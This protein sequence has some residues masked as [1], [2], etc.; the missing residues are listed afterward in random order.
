MIKFNALDTG[1]LTIVDLAGLSN[2]TII[3]GN[4]ASASLSPLGTIA[5][6][7]LI[8]SD[9][10][11]RSRLITSKSSQLT[12]QIN[13]ADK[14]RDECFYEIR[15][16]SS[17]AAKSSITVNAAAGETLETFLKPYNNAPKEPMMSETSTLK[18]MQTKYIADQVLQNAAVT[19]QLSDVFTNMFSSNDQVS[20][21][22]NARALEDAQKNGPSPSNLRR[23][24][25][26]CY[27]SFCDIVVQSLR[28][29]PTTPIENLFGV[30]NEIRIKYAKFLPT[31]LT[32]ANTSI[33][34]IPT[35]TYT[36]KDVT[37]IPIVSV[38]TGDDKFNELRFSVDY[39]VTYRNNIDVGEAKIIVHGKGKYQGSY[40]STFHIAVNIE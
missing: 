28:L 21:L 27:R 35:Q 11:F 13:K 8:V 1:K 26:K 36:G 23:D 15:R 6:N 19:L 33:E 38:K 24:L 20:A 29:Q 31:K 17:A 2:E 5:L 40:L 25:E 4:A 12:E 16:I 34:S 39:T 10:A 37:P 7:K 18:F 3:A 14:R 22:W 32:E 9:S 30:M